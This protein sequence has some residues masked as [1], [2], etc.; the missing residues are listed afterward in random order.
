MITTTLLTDLLCCP[1]SHEPLLPLADSKLAALNAAI[2]QGQ[3]QHVDG[4]SVTQ[5]L[6]AALITRHGKVIYPI[7]DGIPVLIHER[8][9]GTT[10]LELTP[11]QPQSP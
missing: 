2:G 4:S 3:V 11:A 10:Q 6:S 1:T 7:E 5:A 9:I 8:G